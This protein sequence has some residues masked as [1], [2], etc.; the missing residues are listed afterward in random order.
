[1]ELEIRQAKPEEMEEFNHSV[2]TA[3]SLPAEFTVNMPPEWTLCAFADNKM[4]TSY[5]VW[6]LTMQFTD[7]SVS[8]AGVTMVGTLPINR[9]RGYLHKITAVHF[10]ILHERGEQSIAALFATM[11]AIYQRYGYAVVS[12]KHSYTVEP[13]YLQFSYSQ[14][15]TGDLQYVDDKEH[16][17]LIELYHRFAANRTG[18]MRRNDK[19][20]VAPGAP[21]TVTTFPQQSGLLHRVV[22]REAGEPLG[23]VIYSVRNIRTEG[24]PRL[25][26][27]RLDIRDLVWLNASA[28]RA[29]WDHLANMD[30]VNEIAWERV[31]PDDPLPHML[32]EPKMLNT[33]AGDGLLA[34]IIDVEKA[35]AER[36]YSGEGVL[37][38][39][40]IDELCP[41]NKGRWKM[42][43][44]AAGTHISRTN[45]EPQL[46]MPISTLAMLVFNQI[47]ATEAARMARLDINDHNAL[48]LWDRVMKTIHRPFCADLF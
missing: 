27:Q 35:L 19:F 11:A 2:R 7:V 34:R 28:Y 13:R 39:E 25:S 47:S 26:I 22:Y 16:E 45:E 31:P 33:R 43:T 38:F 17:L 6:P 4:V 10:N 14:S 21:F 24:P 48:S 42:E 46:V 44:S 9:R 32:L 3:F 15:V 29:I 5:A 37:T 8:V 30:L 1:M 18:Y 36:H 41:W 23:Y 12:T 20:E 40:I